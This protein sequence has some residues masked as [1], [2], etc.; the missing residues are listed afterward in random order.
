MVYS[1]KVLERDSQRGEL[2]RLKLGQADLLSELQTQR[3]LVHKLTRLIN[4][5]E[6]SLNRVREPL[7]YTRTHTHT[8]THTQRDTELL[9]LL[10]IL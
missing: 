6:D 9:L 8:H 7:T 2:A 10:I 3:E 4:A 5:T 1:A